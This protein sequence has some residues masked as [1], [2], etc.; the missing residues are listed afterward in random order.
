MKMILKQN[1]GFHVTVQWEMKDDYYYTSKLSAIRF[2]RLQNF[3]RWW[4][5]FNIGLRFNC[6]RCGNAHANNHWQNPNFLKQNKCYNCWIESIIIYYSTLVLTVHISSYDYT[7]YEKFKMKMK[8]NVK[9]LI[10]C[11]ASD[12]HYSLRYQMIIL[13][14]LQPNG[15]SVV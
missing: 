12:K 13:L 2:G 3:G 15:K 9:W 8:L 7:K 5:R 14:Y 11:R 1:F 4:F 10:S 6:Y